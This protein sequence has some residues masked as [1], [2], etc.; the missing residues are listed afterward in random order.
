MDYPFKVR[1]INISD[2]CILADPKTGKYYTV[3]RHFNS[4]LF[5]WQRDDC[6]T[7]YMIESSN[8]IDWSQPQ[9]VFEQGDFWAGL[10]YWAPELHL[11]KDKYYIISSF[12]APGTCRRCQCLVSDSILGPYTYIRQEPVTPNGWQCLDGTLYI[13]GQGKPWMVFCHEWLQVYDGQIA[14]VPLSDDLGEATGDP[15][16]LFRASDAPWRGS[17]YVT[18][19][20]FLHRMADGALIM[21]WSGFTKHGY[22]TGYARSM[23]GEIQGPW[24]QEPD[25]LYAHD[26]AHS[27]LFHTFEGQLMMALHCPNIHPLKRILLF[28]MEE[29]NSKLAIINEVTGNW[30]NTIRGD[31]ARYRYKEPYI[32]TPAFTKLG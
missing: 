3:A 10:D 2:P 13:D 27:M 25:P 30:Y 20:P 19:G 8:L 29:K 1:D 4:D 28:E 5:P 31:A 16:I 12:R 11:Y 9:L 22:A 15:I 7:F 18:D 26:G 24:V 32:D 21:L 17:N 6:G 14:A 23:S